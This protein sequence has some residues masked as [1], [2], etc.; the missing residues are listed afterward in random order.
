MRHTIWDNGRIMKG[1]QCDQESTETNQKAAVQTR[2]GQT[3]VKAAVRKG[4]RIMTIA[5][6]QNF[7]GGVTGKH[8]RPI[9]KSWLKWVRARLMRCKAMVTTRARHSPHRGTGRRNRLSSKS[10]R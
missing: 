2:D 3:N 6:S 7:A 10:W 9:S 4:A 5:Y 8:S 1:D